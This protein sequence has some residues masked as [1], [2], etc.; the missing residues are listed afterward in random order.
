MKNELPALSSAVWFVPFLL[1]RNCDLVQGG[2]EA[3]PLSKA[4][5]V[6]FVVFS[7]VQPL[8][9]LHGYSQQ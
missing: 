5:A 4:T 1:L 6:S 8:L 2:A 7:P 9:S 3:D